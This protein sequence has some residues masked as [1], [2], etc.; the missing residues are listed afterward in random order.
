MLP[1]AA[2][3]GVLADAPV[4]VLD[5]PL[6][7]RAGDRLQDATLVLSDRFRGDSL[8]AIVRV[9]GDGVLI[10]NVRIIGSSVWDPAWDDLQPEARLGPGVFGNT[11]GIR[12]ENV[13]DV[14]VARV[15]IEGLPRA[16]I[17]G[18]GISGGLFR[19]ISIRHC[20]AG[21]NIRHDAPSQGLRLDRV[22]TLNQWG[23]P[24]SRDPSAERPEGWIGGDGFALN[25]LRDSVI[26]D[27]TSSGEMF[28]SFKLTNPQR[29]VVRRLRG[30]SLMVQ[31]TAGTL[32]AQWA[33][34]DEPARDVV[35]ED[36]VFDKGLGR[37]QSLH[38][39]N[40]VQLS[41]NIERVEVRRC[42][43][44]AAG[45]NG[46]GIQMTQDVIGQV[47]DCTIR[48]F[49]GVRGTNPAHALDLAWNSRVNPDFERVNSFVDQHRILSDRT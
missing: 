43:L 45:K 36:C 49:N 27:C 6:V 2:R 16:A 33:I 47:R 3:A 20:Y 12:I 31:G 40:C 4:E 23:P 30:A 9:E 28:T 44:N 17:S 42:F 39:V 18:Y 35:I 38:D 24:A 29:V 1:G 5:A 26:V 13:S 41:Q 37:G 48:G 14:I 8:N 7:L 46:H 34:H 22:H 11:N 10:R 21:I 15:A 19:D 25:S 32:G